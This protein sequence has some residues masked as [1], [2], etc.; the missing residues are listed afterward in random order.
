MR[1]SAISLAQ[2]EARSLLFFLNALIQVSKRILSRSF[3]RKLACSSLFCCALSVKIDL[4]ASSFTGGGAWWVDITLILCPSAPS[5]RVHL[6]SWL[7][8]SFSDFFHVDYN[9][10]FWEIRRLRHRFRINLGLLLRKLGLSY[11]LC[12][13][14]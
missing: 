12:V 2:T 8:S 13:T 7:N 1:T 14:K 9:R 5:Y 11:R 3:R 6:Y 4:V 10:G